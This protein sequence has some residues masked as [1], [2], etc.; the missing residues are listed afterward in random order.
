MRMPDPGPC[1]IRSYPAVPES[2][3]RARRALTA[4]AA[5]AGAAGKEL[6]DIR[7][8]ASEALTNVVMHAYAGG[9]GLMHVTAAAAGGE[10]SVLIA[11]DGGGLRAGTDAPGLGLGLAL[12]AHA[13]DELTVMKRASGGT[14]LRMR[15]AL[16]AAGPSSGDQPRGSVASA[17]SPA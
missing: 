2:V 8:A 14:E 4:F 5:A 6:D 10:V 3:P 1:L 9:S 15:F 11:D 7:L 13:C 12:I 17:A 16:D